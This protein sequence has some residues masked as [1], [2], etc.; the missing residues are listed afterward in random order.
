MNSEVFQLLK[1]LQKIGK[2]RRIHPIGQ[3]IIKK[4]TRIIE[5]LYKYDLKTVK[6]TEVDQQKLEEPEKS[7]ELNE[8]NNDNRKG[9]E[10]NEQKD[11]KQKRSSKR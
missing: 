5:I 11:K 1:D 3:E 2:D 7:N 8:P 6:Y 4:S 9:D 10:Q